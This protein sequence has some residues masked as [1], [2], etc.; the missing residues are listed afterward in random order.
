MNATAN[1]VPPSPATPM[2]RTL[3]ASVKEKVAVKT[4]SQPLISR[5][6]KGKKKQEGKPKRALSAYNFFFKQER[7]H[8][9]DR[10][11]RCPSV[12]TRKSHGK[13]GFADLARSVAA[14]WNSLKTIDK[15]DFEMEAKLD[16]ERYTKELQIWSEKMKTL[17]S[18]ST[19]SEKGDNDEKSPFFTEEA[20]FMLMEEDPMIADMEVDDDD[21]PLLFNNTENNEDTDTPNSIVYLV[22]P[23]PLNHEQ[24]DLPSIEDSGSPTPS[25]LP[26]F[27]DMQDCFFHISNCRPILEPRNVVTPYNKFTMMHSEHDNWMKDSSLSSQHHPFEILEHQQAMML[28]A[29][30]FHHPYHRNEH[31]IEGYDPGDNLDSVNA[32]ESNTDTHFYN[33]LNKS[34]SELASDLDDDCLDMLSH[35]KSIR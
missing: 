18:T 9:L 14:Q 17:P 16:S 10:R 3:V 6:R 22:S 28:A 20:T 29:P 30:L 21:M 25:F 35:F 32:T 7:K 26:D 34:L 4:T 24:R 11:E 5:K 31:H 15:K 1:R 27:S 33:E 13:I 19:L 23:S 12:K 2:A 8:I